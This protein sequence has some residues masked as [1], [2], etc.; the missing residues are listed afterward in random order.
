MSLA[1]YSGVS[2]V[3]SL[4]GE[5]ETSTK[6]TDTHSTPATTVHKN[7]DWVVSYWSDKNAS[8]T[9]WSAP[10]GQHVRAQPVPGVNVGSVRVTGLLTDDGGP[11]AGGA[12]AGMQGTASGSATKASTFSIVLSSF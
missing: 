3:Q 9:G 7:G 6:S 1:A 10:D 4:I 2:S 11:A 8:T 12:R 5:Q